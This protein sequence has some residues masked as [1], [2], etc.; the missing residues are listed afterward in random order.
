M[1]YQEKKKKA[2]AIAVACY[3]EQEK[4][5]LQ[6]QTVGISS[7]SWQSTGRLM[8]MNNRQI[9]QRRGRVL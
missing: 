7:S 1:T 6:A 3:I 4:A 9:V 5:E 2:I 8:Q